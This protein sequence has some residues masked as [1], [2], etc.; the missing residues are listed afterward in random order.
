M[1]RVESFTQYPA[2]FLS[3]P[4]RSRGNYKCS[5]ALTSTQI[6]PFGKDKGPSERARYSRHNEASSSKTT[7]GLRFAAAGL[8]PTKSL[9]RDP[10]YVQQGYAST[11]SNKQGVPAKLQRT[12]HREFLV[13]F[14]V[15]DHLLFLWPDVPSLIIV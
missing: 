2:C 11:T 10:Y 4:D 13:L 6:T 5:H 1:P 12:S 15:E 8:N 14:L 3:A 9:T 7:K